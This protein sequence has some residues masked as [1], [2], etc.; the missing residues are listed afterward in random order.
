MSLRQI[1]AELTARGVA[2]PRGGRCMPKLSPACS[3]ESYNRTSASFIFPGRGYDP[4]V[5]E[6]GFL[7]IVC[8]KLAANKKYRLDQPKFLRQQIQE[9]L[10]RHSANVVGESQLVGD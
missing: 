9:L 8:G 10:N 2:T 1:A 6:I 4:P 3:I 7:Q 5:A